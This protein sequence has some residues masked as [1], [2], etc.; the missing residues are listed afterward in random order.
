MKKIILLFLSLCPLTIMFAQSEEIVQQNALSKDSTGYM[1]FFPDGPITYNIAYLV[2]CYVADYD[3]GYLGCVYTESITGPD[4]T[5]VVKGKEYKVFEQYFDIYV[6][7]DVVTGKIF[8]YYPGLDTEVVVCD[9][10]LSVGDTFRMPDVMDKLGGGNNYYWNYYYQETNIPTIVD[11]VVNVDGRKVIYLKPLNESLYFGEL[12]F[13]ELYPN[14]RF[15][16][17]IG[18][19]YGPFGYIN[20]GAGAMNMLL[21]VHYG[22]S[23]IYMN[24]P[25]LGCDQF[26]TGIPEYPES[27]LRLY[28][29]PAN[30]MLNV[31]LDGME[32][33]QG[34]ITVMD[35]AGVVVHAQECYSMV[36]QL[37][38][39]RL[40]SGIYV[41]VFRNGNGKIVKKFV[42]I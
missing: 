21:C 31:E 27:V 18:P 9:M 39:S 12:F 26:G 7:E 24:N 4:T 37:D 20:R 17:G 28:P 11:S 10:S 40:K 36:T 19:T 32:N 42:K 38:V 13:P 35:M 41:V 5:V 25:I 33:P 14:L 8:R 2:N 3:P 22:E 16:E 15:I 1:P 23:L 30:Q 29:N 6:R 34:V